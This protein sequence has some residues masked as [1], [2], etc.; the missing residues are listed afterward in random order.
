LRSRWPPSSREPVGMSP[1]RRCPAPMPRSALAGFRFHLMSSC[2]RSAGTCRSASPPATSRSRSPSAGR[3]RPWHRLPL[4]AAPHAAPGRRRQPM[5]PHRRDRWQVDET[6]MKVA[7]RWRSVYRAIDQFGSMGSYPPEE[8]LTP[9]TG[10]WSGR[11]AR[12][13]WH[14]SRWSRIGHRRTPRCSRSCSQR[15]GTAPTG[16]PPTASR[17]PTVLSRRGLGRCEDS[18][19]TGAPG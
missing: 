7:G 12:P 5:P 19:R 3:G 2:G 11:S 14:R 8:T 16:T 9:P 4:G 15:R 18:T 13:S 6:S 10:A 17:L 1:R